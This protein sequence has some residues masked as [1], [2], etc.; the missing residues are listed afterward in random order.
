MVTEPLE[1]HLVV[2]RSNLHHVLE[3]YQGVDGTV[4]GVLSSVSNESLLGGSCD[5]GKNTLRHQLVVL[6]GT[7]LEVCTSRKKEDVALSLHGH[8]VNLAIL[9]DK[10]NGNTVCIVKLH[11]LHG[12][13]SQS[14]V[15]STSDELLDE[16]F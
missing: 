1:N 10:I 6:G 12:F 15:L 14:S 5:R 13:L 8:G 11:H 2:Q 9:S 4:E 3:E 7:S 16:L